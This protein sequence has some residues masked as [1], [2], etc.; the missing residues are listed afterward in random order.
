[1]LAGND[2]VRLVAC[3]RGKEA[4]FGNTVLRD[5]V[6]S[7]ARWKAPRAR[8]PSRGHPP[9]DSPIDGGPSSRTIAEPAMVK[10][11]EATLL[12]C[13]EGCKVVG[14]DGQ[15]ARTWKPV[16]TPSSCRASRPT[17]RSK[18]H[19]SPPSRCSRRSTSSSA[20]HRTSSASL[21]AARRGSKA[22]SVSMVLSPRDSSRPPPASASRW[23]LR[24]HLPWEESGQARRRGDQGQP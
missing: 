8:R 23:P 17:P 19:P 3:Q 14:M 4:W 10:C 7:D 21:P 9:R 13:S 2:A 18:L 5:L 20:S 15:D 12:T 11:R 24:P 16:R 1:M 22:T 6:E